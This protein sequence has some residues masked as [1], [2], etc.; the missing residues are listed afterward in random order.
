MQSDAKTVSLSRHKA[1]CSIC[2]HEKCA[3]METAFEIVTNVEGFNTQ[4]QD[5][6]DVLMRIR[7]EPMH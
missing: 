2:A 3:E 4:W 7:Y 6:G 5:F 1:Q